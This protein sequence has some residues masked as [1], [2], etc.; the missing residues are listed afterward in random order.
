MCTYVATR[1]EEVETKK[2]T[3]KFWSTLRS[4][5]SKS[6]PRKWR[7]NKIKS[8]LECFVGWLWQR[9]WWCYVALARILSAILVLFFEGFITLSKNK[10][11]FSQEMNLMENVKHHI[12]PWERKKSTFRG[13]SRLKPSIGDVVSF[14]KLKEWWHVSL[15]CN[16]SLC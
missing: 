9:I 14:E 4:V 1:Y 16:V 5:D 13:I 10:N 15:I 7:K 2:D 8:L 6:K 3:I 11:N 12:A